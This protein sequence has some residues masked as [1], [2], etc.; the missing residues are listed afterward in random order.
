MEE[1]NR[2]TVIRNELNIFNSN[3]TIH[4]NGIHCIYHDERM[5]PDRIPKQLM[6]YTLTGARYI[7]RPTPSSTTARKKNLKLEF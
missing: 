4:N 6:G 7:V 2:N 5:E 3:N 1:W